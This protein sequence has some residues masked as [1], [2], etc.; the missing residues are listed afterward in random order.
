[1]NIRLCFVLCFCAFAFGGFMVPHKLGAGIN[2]N[3]NVPRLATEF[4]LIQQQRKK[5]E[6]NDELPFC[7]DAEDYEPV[8][9]PQ[10]ATAAW[11]CITQ[12]EIAGEFAETPETG[13]IAYK[14]WDRFSKIPYAS[15]HV[16]RFVDDTTE[17][18]VYVM[19]YAND[20]A[21][22]YGMYEKSGPMPAGGVL[23]KYSM[24]VSGVGGKVE[25]API[26]I[27]QK[28][29]ETKSP[30]TKG[31]RYDFIVP[32]GLKNSAKGA[33]LEFS[34]QVCASCHMEYGLK[35][36]SMLFMPAEVR[37]ADSTKK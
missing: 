8:L 19:N 4:S 36:D 12:K 25:L 31:W 2:V 14:E 24:I 27:M 33:D 22:S 26:Y 29:G 23:A 15:A 34:Q 35:T 17:Q 20:R 28:V 18:A 1:M 21:R 7:E 32:A 11:D 9:T 16:N 30:D 10:E 6:E 3:C 5:C 13:S 37:I